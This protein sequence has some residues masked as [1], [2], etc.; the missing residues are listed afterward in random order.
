MKE[1]ICFR[2]FLNTE[3]GIMRHTGNVRFA[4]FFLSNDKISA[5]IISEKIFPAP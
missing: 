2:I 5:I 3:K 1:L 4:A